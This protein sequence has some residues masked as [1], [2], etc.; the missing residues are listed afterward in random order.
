M[1]QQ[2]SNQRFSAN[3]SSAETMVRHNFFHRNCRNAPS[4]YPSTKSVHRLG[5]RYSCRGADLQSLRT[6]SLHTAMIQTGFLFSIHSF[7]SD[8][9]N[10]LCLRTV[11]VTRD[12]TYQR[13]LSRCICTIVHH[14]A[15][16]CWPAY[17]STLFQ[18]VDFARFPG[19]FLEISNG[20]VRRYP[21]TL[22]LQMCVDAFSQ[23]PR[24]R[25]VYADL[26]FL[27]EADSLQPAYPRFRLPHQNNC[28]RLMEFFVLNRFANHSTFFI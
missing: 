3:S 28:Q 5:C 19:G 7:P 22:A 17:I 23:F 13:F 21:A 6:T 27:A 10:S 15:F 25:P 18:A 11:K 1:Q 2:Y 9:S 26:R 20:A 14:Q 4:K 8:L 16:P 24:S 12:V